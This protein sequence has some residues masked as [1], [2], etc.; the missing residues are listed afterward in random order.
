MN[1]PPASFLLS[2]SLP[3][4]INQCT[5]ETQ[6]TPNETILCVSSFPLPRDT[7]CEY[8]TRCRV[9]E[10]GKGIAR[11]E[12]GQVKSGKRHSHI[13]LFHLPCGRLKKSREQER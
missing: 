3:P 9:A 12:K 4:P 6:P 10:R 5:F 8:D 1:D 2:L 7:L 11:G 13:S